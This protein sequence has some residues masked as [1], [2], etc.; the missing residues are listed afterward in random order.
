M[1]T[2]T[3][4]N[5]VPGMVLPTQKGMLS[6]NPKDS[7]IQYLNNMNQKQ[8][9]LV[10][11]VGGSK[12]RKG[13]AISVPQYQMLYPV[14]NGPGQDPNSQIMTNSATGIQAAANRSYDSLATNMTGGSFLKWGCYSGGR[15]RTRKT[16]TRK[17]RTRKTRTRKTRTRKTKTRKTKTRKTKT[18]TR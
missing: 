12:K 5:S 10:N 2:Q 14:Q 4:G 16:K 3:V 8:A 11:A 9:S 17:T 18:R 1:T 15:M 13:G 6:S 7:A